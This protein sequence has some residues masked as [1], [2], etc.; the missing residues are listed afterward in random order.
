MRFGLSFALGAALA[1][2]SSAQAGAAAAAPDSPRRLVERVTAY[3]LSGRGDTRSARFL[4]FFTPELRAAIV[5]D[6]SG[7]DLN[8]I[9]MDVLCQ[10]QSDCT[11]MR[12]VSITNAGKNGVA[13]VETT[14]AG[15]SPE[16]ALWTL[17]QSAG[18]WRIADIRNAQWHS[19]LAEL[20]KSNRLQ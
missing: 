17:R 13:K 18:H 8:V 3:E 12:L 4:D 1:V 14:S 6:M 11:A 10:T 5:K 15:G 7:P 16:Q 2:S 20:Q 19:L 9:D